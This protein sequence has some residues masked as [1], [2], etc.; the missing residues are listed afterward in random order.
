MPLLEPPPLP[1]ITIHVARDVTADARATGGFLNLRRLDL[2]VKYPDGGASAPFAYDVATRDA[3]DAV[4]VVAHYRERG[5]RHVYL[6]SAVRPPIALRAIAPEHDG[7]LWEVPAGLIDPGEAPDEAA[8]RELVEELGLTAPASAMKPLGPWGFPVPAMIGER[9]VYLHV[10]VD[11]STR[12][13]PTE[14]G[15]ALERG[16]SIV[17]MALGDALDLCRRGHVRD[18]KSELALRRLAELVGERTWPTESA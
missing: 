15:S 11:P 17:A 10:E 2:V 1:G 18:L 14:D 16:A 12:A 13:T 7:R 5:V 9:H 8:A 6:R 3:L 4:V